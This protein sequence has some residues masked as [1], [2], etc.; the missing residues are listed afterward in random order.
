MK[1]KNIEATHRFE[2][3]KLK[4]YKCPAGKWTIG[5]GSTRYKDSVGK[6]QAVTEGM[7]I[8]EWQADL[9]FKEHLE[10]DE[11]F[12]NKLML[13][14]NQNEFDALIDF[15]YNV[16]RGAFM[17]STLL[18]VIQRAHYK[19]Q[20]MQVSDLSNGEGC[21]QF[22]IDDGIKTITVLQ[23]NF[24]RWCWAINP[25]LGRKEPSRG[26]YNRKSL[27]HKLY[28]KPYKHGENLD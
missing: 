16:G 2:G 20:L 10:D 4:A 12:L 3:L 11:K 27:N 8:T 13:L 24:I 15:I 26:L 23:Y 17:S 7:I 14:L 5:Y 6:W 19:S 28:I 25:E 1:L 22:L 18:N 9:F 21:K